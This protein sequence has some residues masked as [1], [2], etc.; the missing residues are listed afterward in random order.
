MAL[1]LQLRKKE[2]KAIRLDWNITIQAK[3]L[4]QDTLQA[5]QSLLLTREGLALLAEL[6]KVRMESIVRLAT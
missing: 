5:V 6:K 1:A 4:S 2:Q 3:Q